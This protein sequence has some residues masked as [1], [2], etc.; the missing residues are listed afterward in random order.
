MLL[1]VWNLQLSASP[2]QVVW[3]GAGPNSNWSTVSNWK[4][5]GASCAPPMQNNLQGADV[6]FPAG[7]S[8]AHLGP[9]LTSTHN[10]LTLDSLSVSGSEFTAF[11]LNSGLNLTING[12]MSTF[13]VTGN[14]ATTINT[15]TNDGILTFNSALT[16]K[17]GLNNFGTLALNANVTNTGG[18]IKNGGSGIVSIGAS[19]TVTGGALA[20]TISNNGA[21]SGVT[22]G[23][24]AT[25]ATINGGTIA[26]VSV[27]SGG[28]STNTFKG[29]V[30]NTGLLTAGAGDKI[31][32]QGGTNSGALAAGAG[33]LSISNSVANTGGVIDRGTYSNG[34]TIT[35]G[36]VQGAS[37]LSGSATFSG[38][39]NTTTLNA[40]AS[41]GALNFQGGTNSGTLQ[42]TGAGATLTTSG[43]ITNTGGTIIG[44]TN[45]GTISG[46]TVSGTTTGTGGA[47]NNVMFSGV[48]LTNG[49]I[50]GANNTMTGTNTLSGTVINNGTVTITA[51]TTTVAGGATLQA[52]SGTVNVNGGTLNIVGTVDPAANFLL[53]SGS[54]SLTGNLYVNVAD[55]LGGTIDGPGSFEGG[56]VNNGDGTAGNGAQGVLLNV[57]GSVASGGNG[58]GD[59]TFSAYNQD[60][61]GSLGITFADTS[62]GG[63]DGHDVL[64]VTGAGALLNGTL[65]L[66]NSA[67]GELDAGTL[68]TNLV[69]ELI[70][71]SG[72]KVGGPGFGAVNALG[73]VGKAFSAPAPITGWWLVYNG[74]LAAGEGDVELVYASTPEPATGVLL[75]GAM[76]G[77]VIL[78]KRMI[79]R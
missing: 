22:Y 73:I 46:G 78:R 19:A 29:S 27:T 16:N 67:G 13:N 11:T 24:G 64:T 62:Q 1:L 31:V 18:V 72:G 7:L 6:I 48:N 47:F 17:S 20:G 65:N 28:G 42:A 25:G 30:T 55:L 43:N 45:S 5:N 68:N 60:L 14:G 36:K 41:G 70:D 61:G 51:G 58:T 39:N 34:V 59:Y 40:A 77:L 8:S 10:G 21:I 69:Y 37:T 74:A 75:G 4:C 53:T 44:A 71:D 3:T 52:E 38:V 49:T 79:R 57:G 23:I 9:V 66:Y 32:W 2:L 35:G 50:T 15:I 54:V 26:G 56:V 63:L 33:T 76:V 12:A